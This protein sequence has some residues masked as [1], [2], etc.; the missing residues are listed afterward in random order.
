MAADVK[1]SDAPSKMPSQQHNELVQIQ[2]D[3]ACPI[4]SGTR[5]PRGKGDACGNPPACFPRRGL[6]SHPGH[7]RA[8]PDKGK[9]S[10]DG[11]VVVNL[12]SV[13][14]RNALRDPHNVATFLL[15][16]FHKS[17][18]HTKMELV[19]ESQ[20]VQLHLPGRD[21]P[22]QVSCYSGKPQPSRGR[23]TFFNGIGRGD[24]CSTGRQ[25]RI[26]RAPT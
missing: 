20:L 4:L 16:Q 25:H 9:H 23:T 24:F 22:E 26:W 11:N 21:T 3:L 15:F 17:V 14:L 13:A 19:Q 7:L 6:R 5:S 18:K 2:H 8:L 1:P 10:E 12:C